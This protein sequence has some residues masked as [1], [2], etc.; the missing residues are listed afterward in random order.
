[1]A[2]RTDRRSSYLSED[3]GDSHKPV[4]R[5][6]SWAEKEPLRREALS[7]TIQTRETP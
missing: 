7:K 6:R 1:M 5:P 3:I 2:T 4:I